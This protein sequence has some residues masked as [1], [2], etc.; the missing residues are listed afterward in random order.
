M[1]D[2]VIKK[3]D[4][5]RVIND[6]V[7]AVRQT[8]DVY[9]GNI[10]STGFKHQIVE[11]VQNSLDQ[12]AKGFSIDKN[13]IV[14][15]DTRTHVVIVEDFGQGVPL[16]VL[17]AAFGT[18]HSSSNYDKEDGSGKY[19]SGKNG[20]GATV[21]NYLSRFFTVESKRMDGTG[22]KVEFIE[23]KTKKGLQPLKVN[24]GEH[25]LRTSFAPTEMMAEGEVTSQEVE[26]I[27]WYLAHVYPIGVRITYNVIEPDGSK[28]SVIIEN[29]H[30]IADIL[31]TINPSPLI[32]P[33]HF[34]VDNGT[35]AFEFL[36]SYDT[37][38][39]DSEPVV[40]SFGNMCQ[41]TPDSVHVKAFLDS[42]SKFFRNY[43]NKIYLASSKKKLVVN[44]QDTRTGLKA[45]VLCKS[46]HPLFEGQAKTRYSETAMEPF[47]AE[48]TLTGLDLWSKKN[49]QQLDKLCHF[50]RDV[51]DARMSQDKEKIRISDKYTSSAVTGYPAKYRKHN[52][53]GPFEL[54]IVEGESAAG[55]IQNDRIKERQGFYSIRGKF[56]N[57]FCKS[58]KDMFENAEVCAITQICGYK[59]Y[60]KHFDPDLFKPEKVI[61]A[62]DADPDGLFCICGHIQ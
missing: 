49:P 52:G 14:S 19:S 2:Q 8:P 9:I 30:G 21:T 29:E 43:M 4:E 10:G 50:L 1:P 59:G 54:I 16:D 11:I 44:Q 25:G 26:A 55:A 62:T 13:V 38:N 53:R 31:A 24:P 5:I 45:V 39:M 41:T 28:R 34:S 12:I 57:A 27:L 46:L 22:G 23:G 33:I 42:I 56:P 35:R 17:V 20:A 15:Y 40:I 47:A 32:P 48:N 6:P 51:C 18:L 58:T 7:A 37:T 36:F 60:S 3:Q 61:I